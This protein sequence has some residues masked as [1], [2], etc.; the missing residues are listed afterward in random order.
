MAR[1][2]WMGALILAGSL[3]LATAAERTLALNPAATHVTFT[4]GSTLHTVH[5]T[6]H[7]LE[8][9][10]VFDDE[11]GTASGQVVIDATSAETGNKKRDKKMHGEV[12]ESD[13]FP[14]IV[15]TPNGVERRLVNAGSGPL[16]LVG[17]VSVHGSDHPVRL[18]ATVNRDGDAVTADFDLPIPFVEWGMEDPSVFVFRTDKDVLVHVELEGMLEVAN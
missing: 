3:N 2:L 16:T 15:F 18:D 12:L 8:G 5:G 7:L 13:A 1:K 4:L 17:S 9:V 10:I 11:T 14:T 6:M